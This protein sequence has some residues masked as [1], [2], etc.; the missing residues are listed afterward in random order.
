MFYLIAYD[1]AHPR[2]LARVARR[3][4]KGAFRVQYS[5]F[6]FE[7]SRAELRKLLDTAAQA[8]RPSEDRLQAWALDARETPEGDLRGQ[9]LAIFPAGAVLGAGALR[10]VGR[11]QPRK[12]SR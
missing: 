8:I 1:I 5:V 4:E 7:G 6:M 2:R 10:L 3:L 9:A 11:P 12:E